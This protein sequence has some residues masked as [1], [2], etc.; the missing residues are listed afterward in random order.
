MAFFHKAR[1]GYQNAVSGGG[2]LGVSI[3]DD[4]VVSEGKY[5]GWNMNI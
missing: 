3:V 5:R 1:E 2:N 4:E